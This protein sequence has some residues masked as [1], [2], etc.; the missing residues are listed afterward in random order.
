MAEAIASTLDEGLETVI[1]QPDIDQAASAGIPSP[2]DTA[3]MQRS[4][5]IALGREKR[6]VTWYSTP[7][8]TRPRTK[9]S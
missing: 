5:C 2:V 1:P 7:R 9:S 8:N 3:N 6:T 4:D